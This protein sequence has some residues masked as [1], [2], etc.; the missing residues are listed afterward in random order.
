MNGYYASLRI[1][2][3]ATR[4]EI[5]DAF[6]RL[7]GSRDAYKTFVIKQLLNVK[8]RADYDAT[9]LGSVFV[10]DYL[11]QS[12]QVKKKGLKRPLEMLDGKGLGDKDAPVE[13]DSPESVSH[14]LDRVEAWRF[15]YYLLGRAG[16]DKAKLATWQRELITALGGHTTQIAVGLMEG[17]DQPWDVRTVGYRVVVFLDGD[18]QPTSANAQAAAIRVMQLTGRHLASS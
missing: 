14:P 10:D 16:A 15:S 6:I 11:K 2:P 17:L 5:R 3:K 4:G 7:N 12:L 9:P 18:E 8:I 1:S 13:T